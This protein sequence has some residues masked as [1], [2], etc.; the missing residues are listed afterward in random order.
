M[1]VGLN[2]EIF[3]QKKAPNLTGGNFSLVE[4]NNLCGFSGGLG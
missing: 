3:R 1:I 2:V 4:T